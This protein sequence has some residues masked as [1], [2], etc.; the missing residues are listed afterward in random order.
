MALYV[1]S[2]L[3]LSLGG[4]K[5]MDIFPGWEGYVDRIERNWKESV[6]DDDTVILGGDTSWALDLPG[7]LQDFLFIEGLPGKKFI[8][9][10]NHDYFWTT[11][12]KMNA[13]FSQNGINSI[14]ILHNNCVCVEGICVC[15]TRGW[16]FD[17]SEPA[18]Q[19]VILREAGRLR[20]SLAEG[21]KTGLPIKCFLH[22]PPIFGKERCDEILAV[23]HEYGVN[24][25]FYGHIHGSGCNY[26]TQGPVNGVEYKMTSADYLK[27]K[28]FRV[29]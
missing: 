14:G 3:H 18:D 25:C 20:M 12:S 16:I 21:A 19:K 7:A 27:F 4:E 5:P 9:K 2:D 29:L 8:L 13:F 15:G 23:L 28:P 26:A 6:R 22:Y 1:I 17:G 11:V 24:Q 10:G